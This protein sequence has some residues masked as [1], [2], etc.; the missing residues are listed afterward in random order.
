MPMDYYEDEQEREPWEKDSMTFSVKIESLQEELFVSEVARDIAS[1]VSSKM[2]KEIEKRAEETILTALTKRVDDVVAD[3]VSKGMQATMQPSDQFSNPKGEP[4][5][6]TEFIAEK[7]GGYLEEK[8]ND[9][10][11]PYTGGYSERA[12]TRLNH[13]LRGVINSEF[14]KEV[15]SGVTEIKNTIRNQM[16]EAAAEWLAKFQAE[17]VTGI[18][19]AKALASRT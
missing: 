7:A 3:L 19:K 6:L 16:K 2:I 9:S 8:V 1:R 18:E 13:H 15:N 10:G 14:E 17:T 5:T 12:Q 4:I 11:A